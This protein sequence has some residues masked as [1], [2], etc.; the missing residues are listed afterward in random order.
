VET[1]SFN[2]IDTL[3]KLTTFLQKASEKPSIEAG[4]KGRKIRVGQES[5]SERAIWDKFKSL[6][7]KA[8]ATQ[9][10]WV[11]T[12]LCDHALRILKSE[13]EKT[14][15]Y[16]SV[17][18]TVFFFLKDAP[19]VKK[20]SD[21]VNEILQKTAT[22]STEK[23]QA[24]RIEAFVGYWGTSYPEVRKAYSTLSLDGTF[25]AIAKEIVKEVPLKDI[26]GVKEFIKN[27]LFRTCNQQ[28]A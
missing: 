7:E 26:N 9:E 10:N 25:D 18:R 6:E 28:R 3:D 15:W 13:P 1:P 27:T 24:S 8:S 5:V 20:D 2:Q 21:D 4:W 14:P 22:D 19:A 12:G 23:Q 17:F 11:K 16:I